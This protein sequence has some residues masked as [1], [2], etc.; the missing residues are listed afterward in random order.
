MYQKLKCKLHNKKKY[1]DIHNINI[2]INEFNDS[3]YCCTNV[4][5]KSDD[6][7]EK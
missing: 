6:H 5:T 2:N 3:K 4:V 1:F 7:M